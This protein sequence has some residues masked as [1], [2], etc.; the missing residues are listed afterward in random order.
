MCR[1][2]SLECM[3]C[4]AR[5]SLSP[6]L[7]S[8]AMGMNSLR[9][10]WKLCLHSSNRGRSKVPDVYVKHS[11]NGS[12]QI[13]NIN[14]TLTWLILDFSFSQDSILVSNHLNYSKEMPKN[15]LTKKCLSSR[16]YL[17]VVFT[18]NDISGWSF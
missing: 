13:F 12:Q 10:V 3:L 7:C 1:R 15:S 14:N 2:I 18:V 5:I 4:T 17:L 8:A 16:Y 9:C 6:T 11:I